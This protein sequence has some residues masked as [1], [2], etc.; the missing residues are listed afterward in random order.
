MTRC[1]VRKNCVFQNCT[2]NRLLTVPYQVRFDLLKK[3]SLFVPNQTRICSD[4]LQNGLWLDVK[5]NGLETYT[6]NMINDLMSMYQCAVS[7]PQ[8]K[9]QKDIRLTP[10]QF[11]ELLSQ[12]NEMK[13]Q[14][15]KI[16]K[17]AL[18]VYLM[19]LRTGMTIEQLADKCGVS[20][21]TIS[22][23]IRIARQALTKE[24]VPLNIG[25]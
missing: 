7:L 9:F 12:L 20:F 24:F 21:G 2:E 3:F 1:F 14:Y 25:I 13:S 6:R 5:N 15:P 8:D 22:N 19:R 23:R 11:E 18:K 17:Y 16:A 4:H 10:M